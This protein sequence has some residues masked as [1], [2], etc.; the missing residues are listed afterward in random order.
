MA[1]DAPLPGPPANITI[2]NDGSAT[3]Q[4]GTLSGN[5]GARLMANNWNPNALRTNATL[6]YEEWRRFDDVVLQVARERLVVTQELMRRGLTYDLPNALGVLQLTWQTAG[7]MNAAEVTMTGL[8]EADKDLPDFSI[9]SMPIPMIH[10]E[11]QIDRRTL[12]ASR[13]SGQPLDTTAAEIGMRKVAELVESIIFT[14]L[15]I[16]SNLGNIYGLLNHPN[17]NTGNIAVA[18]NTATGAQILADV[19]AMTTAAQASDNNM[20]GPYMLFVPSAAYIHMSDDFK[21]NGDKSIMQRVMEVPGIQGI[22]PTNKLTGE[23]VLM[24]QLTSDVIRMINGIQPMMVE[25]DSRGGFLLNFMIFCI[26]LPQIRSDYAGQSGI[27][28]YS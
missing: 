26:I 1:F 27:M 18:W 22:M 13:N 25:W 2:L 16:A 23:N 19:L 12:T 20:F 4:G 28:H 11:F 5:S 9:A 15:S 24:I 6:L 21:A 3:R 10:K 7:D 17:R 8:P 14:G